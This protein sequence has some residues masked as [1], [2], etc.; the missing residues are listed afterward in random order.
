MFIPVRKRLG[1]GHIVIAFV[2]GVGASIYA[3]SPII[4]EQIDK[5]KQAQTSKQPQDK[6]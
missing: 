1:T 3:W 4:K 6:S 5:E 2:F